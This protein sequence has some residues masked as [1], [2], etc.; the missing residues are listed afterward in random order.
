MYC[1][2][3]G[4]QNQDEAVFCFACGTKIGMQDSAQGEQAQGQQAGYQPYAQN[5]SIAMNSMPP[6]MIDPASIAMFKQKK[7][8]IALEMD[9]VWG[10]KILNYPSLQ[11]AYADCCKLFEALQQITKNM[12][13]QF[14]SEERPVVPIYRIKHIHVNDWWKRLEID[15]EGAGTQWFSYP[16]SNALNADNSMLMSFL[17]E[18]RNNFS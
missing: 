5:S 8:G 14:N 2:K 13:I 3:C 9:G 12:V 1:F 7:T 15:I 4:K 10:E 6:A 16:D 17:Q 18:A 11:D